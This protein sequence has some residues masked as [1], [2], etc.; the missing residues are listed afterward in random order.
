[1]RVSG[2]S[3]IRDGV[4]FGFPFVES[5]RSLLPLVDEFVLAVGKSCDDTLAQVEAI[6]SPKLKI[7]ETVWDENL[8]RGGQVMA[9]Q[10][11]L[12][13]DRCTGDWCFY[14]QG[15][16]AI[17]E[18]EYERIVDSMR[19]HL[20]NRRVEGLSFRY[21]HFYGSYRLI[22]P[23]PYRRQIR[24][25][26]NGIGVR[27]VGDACGFGIDGRRLRSRRT[28]A[29]MYHYGWVRDPAVQ[30]RK[31][32]KF[33]QFYWEGTPEAKRGTPPP[34]VDTPPHFEFDTAACV[35]FEGTHP[36]VMAPV[37]AAQDWPEP[38][39]Q[40][41]PRW[42]NSK[43]WDGFFRKNFKSIYR[44]VRRPASQQAAT[45]RSKEGNLQDRSKAA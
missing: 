22:N 35:P 16:E 40:F 17:H 20:P 8:R 44:H 11:N 19:R 23:L 12:A 18:Q 13:L 3:I 33:T 1:M 5:I 36:A 41:T 4:R 6:D 15:D 9:Q 32:A 37:I 30:A 34:E 29:Q 45:N 7:F 27:S 38:P 10:T 14:L 31:L 2:F 25:V 26:R 21:R 42:R 24:I 39:Y 28:G 43:W